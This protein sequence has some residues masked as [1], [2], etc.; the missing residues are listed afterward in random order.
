MKKVWDLI[1]DNTPCSGSWN[2]AVDEFLFRS[3]SEMTQTYLRFY[4]WEKPTVSLGYFQKI[5]NVLDI[6]FCRKNGIGIVR[7]ITG[8]KLVLHNK[9]VTYSLCSSDV[10]TFTSTVDDSYRKIS[11][12]LI[13]G[14]GKM[15]LE[16][17]LADKTPLS[18]AK[19]N[20]PCFSFSARNEIKVG[21]K[22][23]I[24]SAQKRTGSKFI[25][26]G[27]LP[28]EEDEDLLMSV[29]SLGKSKENVGMISLSRALGKTL[30]FDQAVRSLTEGISEYFGIEFKKKSF[31][32]GE[33]KT[34][35]KIQHSRY[36][37]PGWSTNQR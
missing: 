6:D 30:D 8:G 22:K 5:Q 15:G 18:Y 24:G 19:G 36:E 14:L 21:G 23:I 4:Q 29:S 27:S 16:A 37:D 31:T 1:V 11:E 10:E 20:L 33:K 7:R 35:Y 25:Q 9:E 3:L 12:S 17:V 28:I 2:M 34:I 32:D 26:H 13:C